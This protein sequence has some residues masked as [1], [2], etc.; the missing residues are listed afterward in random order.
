AQLHCCRE[1]VAV[2]EAPGTVAAQR[3]PAADHTLPATQCAE[4]PE[5]RVVGLGHV[6]QSRMSREDGVVCDRP[7][8]ATVDARLT[9]EGIVEKAILTRQP[10]I[11]DP[12]DT[13]RRHDDVIAGVV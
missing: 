12:L 6:A 9:E 8:P 13:P 11:H 10:A 3:L 5:W 1:G 4:R 2:I 7:E